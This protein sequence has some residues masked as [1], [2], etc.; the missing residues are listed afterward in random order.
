MKNFQELY[1]VIII[2]SNNDFEL[3]SELLDIFDNFT[4]DNK[5]ID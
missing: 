2:L 5:I 3:C 4:V 1:E